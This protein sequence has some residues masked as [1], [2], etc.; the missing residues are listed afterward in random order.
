MTRSWRLRTAAVVAFAAGAFAAPAGC[1][2]VRPVPP[3]LPSPTVS[4]PA[5]PATSPTPKPTTSPP[6]PEPL[7]VPSPGDRGPTVVA[8]QRATYALAKAAG[9]DPR[10]P[11]ATGLS[12][13]LAAGV[14]PRPRG[15]TGRA[16]EIDLARQLLLVVDDG[17]PVATFNTSTGS[18]GTYRYRGR[19]YRA[20]TPPGRHAVYAQVDGLRRSPLGLLWRPKYFTGGIAIHGFTSVPPWPASHGCVRLTYGTLVW[21]Y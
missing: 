10:Q 1:G 14:R 20:V 19:T 3:A 11:D 21:V 6:P 13:A 12:R 16:V 17:R 15:H 2:S 9:L 7:A 8:W 4:S 18:G 5:E